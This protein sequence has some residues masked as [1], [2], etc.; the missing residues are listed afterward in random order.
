MQ[1]G[2]S[3]GNAKKNDQGNN[4]GKPF[5][6]INILP[7]RDNEDF[8]KSFQIF[9]DSIKEAVRL[10]FT[11]AWV[12]PISKFGEQNVCRRRDLDTGLNTVQFNSL[13]A[14]EDPSSVRDFFENKQVI[15]FIAEMKSKHNFL[16]LA[17]FVWKHVSAHSGLIPLKNEKWF[18]KKI[19]DIVEYNFEGQYKN[20]IINLL[21]E[22]IDIYLGKL[23]FSG[24]RFD[25]ASH[26]SP[27]IRKELITYIDASYPQAVILEEVLFDRNEADNIEKLAAEAKKFKIFSSFVTSNLYYQKP[28]AFGALPHPH[29]MGD[30][31]KL[32]MAANNGIGFTGNHDHF[33]VSFETL[34]VM[35]AEKAFSDKPFLELINKINCSP[36]KN[37]NLNP[38]ELIEVINGI[39]NRN[40]SIQELNESDQAVIRYLLP[41]ANEIAREL[42]SAD[43]DQK[44]FKRYQNILFEKIVNRTLASSFGYFVLGSEISSNHFSTQRIFTT[45]TG[46]PLTSLLITA[47]DLLKSNA[48]EKLIGSME[49]DCYIDS[50]REGSV[51]TKH[52]QNI[53]NFKKTCSVPI[54]EQSLSVNKKGKKSDKKSNNTPEYNLNLARCWLPFFVEFLRNNPGELKYIKGYD[55]A[56]IEKATMAFVEK[57]GIK[58]FIKQVNEIYSKLTTLACIDYHTF[59]SLD[60]FKIIVR[61]HDQSTDIIIINLDPNAPKTLNDVDIQKIALWFQARVCPSRSLSGPLASPFDGSSISYLGDE[62]S[63]YWKA[64]DPIKF[65]FAYN[66]I[67]GCASGHKTKLFLGQGIRADLDKEYLK[68]VQV[69]IKTLDE[70]LQEAFHSQKPLTPRTQRKLDSSVTLFSPEKKLDR[71]VQK[72][73]QQSVRKVNK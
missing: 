21:K 28:N 46:Q 42:L 40:R 54:N 63:N 57:L 72:L 22:I 17:D 66:R 2:V 58:D 44:L 29:E 47:S 60:N 31:T 20:E 64:T 34:L 52:Y 25:A 68:N 38:Q 43:C 27:E 15:D 19:K 67:L 6:A 65:D 30:A 53:S 45:R 33:S 62:Y 55:S 14:P 16:I 71:V 39:A 32:K 11:H 23:R 73:D 9:C 3:L 8:E 26:L 51:K 13:Y 48:A 70:E 41:F 12:N 24:L 49:S 50:T 35:A 4:P 10:E 18:G 56:Q 37:D 7:P 36:I 5:I 61:C 69:H 59:T 1:S